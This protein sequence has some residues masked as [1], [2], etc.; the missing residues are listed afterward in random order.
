[1]GI[2][3]RVAMLHR[4]ANTLRS[5]G[6]ID[7]N[8]NGELELGTVG[9]ARTIFHRISTFTGFRREY[10]GKINQG[11]LSKVDRLV[12]KVV[13]ELDFTTAELRQDLQV[14]KLRLAKG[15]FGKSLF[16]PWTELLKGLEAPATMTQTSFAEAH[17][18]LIQEFK[19]F[20]SVSRLNE[21]N[22][23]LH[24]QSAELFVQFIQ[25]ALREGEAGRYHVEFSLIF[26][27]ERFIGEYQYV[28]MDPDLTQNELNSKLEMLYNTAEEE[29]N[30][31]LASGNHFYE[32][33]GGLDM[34]ATEAKITASRYV[35]AVVSL[36]NKEPGILLTGSLDSLATL[37]ANSI[38][39]ALDRLEV[40][41]QQTH[42]TARLRT[43][44]L[45][46][47][48]LYSLSNIKF[49]SKNLIHPWSKRLFARFLNEEFRN[50]KINAEYH[51]K[52]VGEHY[53]GLLSKI[54][55]ME[56][57]IAIAVTIEDQLLAMPI[58]NIPSRKNLEALRDNQ[59][60]LKNE[61]HEL[62]GQLKVL[63]SQFKKKNIDPATL[64]QSPFQEVSGS[65]TSIRQ[66]QT[67]Q[68][69][70]ELKRKCRFLASRSK[71]LCEI[72]KDPFADLYD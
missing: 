47:L 2:P 8:E 61:V 55:E 39:E 22:P 4:I 26:L 19:D 33:F 20:D 11:A 28:I 10:T 59:K 65:E 44:L 17:Q 64:D 21:V 46:A 40:L 34:T 24:D 15:Y 12:S 45:T 30:S 6:D 50:L 43:G 25:Q 48:R 38:K 52:R 31:I 9:V 68:E 5:G 32:L 72:L 56:A 36:A 29:Y 13:A 1:M 37:D 51:Q 41:P 63:L 67:D 66:M 69:I 16:Q 58:S 60:K 27:S 35:E 54:A 71:D 70:E 49:D 23:N 42:L 18:S 53:K 62:E 14:V 57:R 3:E 7:I